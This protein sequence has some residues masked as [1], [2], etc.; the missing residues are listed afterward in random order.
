MCSRGAGK[1]FLFLFGQRRSAEETNGTCERLPFCVD[2]SVNC[3]ST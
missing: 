1:E 2:A 3:F